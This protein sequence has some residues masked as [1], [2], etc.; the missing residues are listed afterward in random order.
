[1]KKLSLITILFFS[2]ISCKG[3]EHKNTAQ[4]TDTLIPQKKSMYYIP[5]VS[6]NFETFDFQKTREE[7]LKIPSKAASLKNS[8]AKERGYSYEGKLDENRFIH[9]SFF[10]IMDESK[11]FIIKP[12]EYYPLEIIYYENSP[13]MIQKTFYPN[14]NIKEKGLKIVKGN[15]YKGNWYYFDENGKLTHTIDNDKL[16]DFS[17]EQVEKFMEENKISMPIGNFYVEGKTSVGRVSTLLYPKSSEKEA[18]QSILKAWGIT[19]KGEE[20]N[21]YY[22]VVLDGDTGKILKRTKYWVSEEGE[23]V[24]V[25]IIED[26]SK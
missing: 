11:K 12:E 7:T 16:F 8:E 10:E 25:P 13:F 9:R 21:Q 2:A 1:M 6:P 19:W 24:P 5:N 3:Q 4:K 18:P 26:F 17:W 15:I 23:D 22:S 20:W 14:G